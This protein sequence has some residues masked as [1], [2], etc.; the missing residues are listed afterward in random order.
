MKKKLGRFELAE[1]ID[2]GGFTNVYR[3][4]ED[5]GQGITRPAAVK[6]MSSFR[7]GDEEDVAALRREVEVLIELGG[8]PN[9]VSILG[10]GIDEDAGAWIAMELGGRSLLHSLGSSPAQPED[11]RVLLRDVLRALV[12]V[13]GSEPQILHRD[14]KPNNI[15]S[16]RGVWKVT[17]FGVAK[18]RGSDETMSL[19]TVKYAAPELLDATLGEE[20]PRL[21]L[22]ALGMVAYEMALG[23]D[24]F[25]KQF[26][27]I[28]DPARGGDK[29]DRD[30]RPKWMFWHT[31]EQMVLPSLSELIEGYPQDLSDLIA[32]MTAKPVA[33][34]I[35]S[36]E[37]ALRR[38]GD[39][40]AT[41]P[42]QEHESEDTSQPKRKLAS[43]LG[44]I[45]T[46]AVFLG[47][48]G[49][50]LYYVLEGRPDIY[51]GSDGRFVGTTETVEVAGTIEN[52][53]EAGRAEVLLRRGA[54]R[55]FPVEM[56]DGGN[57]T[58]GIRLPELGVFSAQLVV[59]DRTGIRLGR[60]NFELERVVPEVVAIL[61][62]TSPVVAG[63]T[64]T[65]RGSGGEAPPMEVITGS[66]G[67]ARAE[68]PY[69]AFD[70][71]VFHPR[72]LPLP[73]SSVETGID[74][75]WTRTVNL[76]ELDYASLA[77]EMQR[78]IDRLMRL[79]DR[80]VNC[81]PGPLT[82]MEEEQVA[83]STVRL[84]ALGNGNE[85]IELF[86]G[87]VARV[88]NCNPESMVAA[89]E[90][91]TAAELESGGGFVDPA[92][93]INRVI[94]R[95]ERLVDRKVNCP[96]GPLSQFEEDALARALD[97]VT[98]LALGDLDIELYVEGVR[99]VKECDPSSRPKDV[100]KK[101]TR[102]EQTREQE[103]KEEEARRHA[104]KS[105]GR[106]GNKPGAPGASRAF[107]PSNPESYWPGGV[108][109][110]EGPAS[111]TGGG[112]SAA[113]DPNDAGSIIASTLAVLPPNPEAVARLMSMPLD[114]FAA[115]VQASVPGGSLE[116]EALEALNMVRVRGPLFRRQE[117]ERVVVR[118]AYGMA[119]I[120]PEI[121][122]DA[123]EVARAL[124]RALR[125]LD[126]TGVQVDAYLAP[127]D[128]TLFAQFE[129]DQDFDPSTAQTL[130]STFVVDQGLLW[131]RGYRDEPEGS[132][133][134]GEERQ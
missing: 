98:S 102:E 38:L 111:L 63:A 64:V 62:E 26:P 99:R 130:A 2:A 50:A 47:L 31:S 19:A 43:I 24:L 90:V 44:A 35:A 86:L 114:E 46:A 72:Y 82:E 100:P 96:P 75:V 13:H 36:A 7:S 107:D 80:K 14:L 32:A 103:L 77:A 108:P 74:P 20:S 22:Y 73:R 69:G 117:L 6:V 61:L 125:N 27:S 126:A 119:R 95:I 129:E 88:E 93:A 60:A 49:G 51:L 54:V 9:I 53:P 97:E 116:V 112:L 30:D 115:F 91:P 42:H 132:P 16:S 1:Q 127:T 85:D 52:F 70:I 110:S 109:G 94:A 104:A 106:Q 76:V 34:R 10:M 28:Y 89:P 84:R 59:K 71:E 15:L 5:M 65:L 128:P 122:I 105:E 41:A 124:D 134:A 113:E 123:W 56:G 87:G 23:G 8:S 118:L 57:F 92:A 39:V 4:Y 17:D 55:S 121:R 37:E 120:Q 40:G 101:L 21:D 18:R 29:E 131:V 67:I 133:P 45:L 81:P 79:M 12:S 25:T 3:A 11:V 48:I 66:D 78:E 83:A 68:L 58:C 33:Q